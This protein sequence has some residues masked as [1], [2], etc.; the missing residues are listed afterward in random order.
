MCTKLGNALLCFQSSN[1]FN[2]AVLYSTVYSKT[3]KC[4]LLLFLSGPDT[5][6]V[7]KS[8]WSNSSVP[9][10]PMKSWLAPTSSTNA[11]LLLASLLFCLKDFLIFLWACLP[12][13]LSRILGIN[14]WERPECQAQLAGFPYPIG[15]S[16]ICAAKRVPKRIKLMLIIFFTST[17]FIV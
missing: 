16:L 3:F 10:A 11:F 6:V 2:S 7:L 1:C 4:V 14:W 8:L 5:I 12:L 9:S 17:S 13:V 15:T